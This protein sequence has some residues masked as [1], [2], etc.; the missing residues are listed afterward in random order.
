M[1]E[2]DLHFLGLAIELSNSAEPRPT[3]YRVGALIVQHGVELSRGF[4]LELGEGTHAE[5]NALSKLGADR[6]SDLTLYS[7]LEPCSER[8]SGSKSCTARIIEARISRVVFALREPA[9]FVKCQGERLLI[10]AGIEVLVLD[11]LAEQVRETNSH[12]GD[13]RS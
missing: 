3:S 5:Q 10:E 12:L 4:S 7:S 9:N 2:Q 11:E 1:R 8:L 6:L 13:L